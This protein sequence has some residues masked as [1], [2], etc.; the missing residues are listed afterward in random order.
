M[1]ESDHQC[2]SF[3]DGIT[4]DPDLICTVCNGSYLKTT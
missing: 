2:I 1:L 4:P 3:A